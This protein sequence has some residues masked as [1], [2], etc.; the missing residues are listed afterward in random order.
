[1]REREKERERKREKGR[2]RRKER[3]ERKREERKE[4]NERSHLIKHN[5][6]QCREVSYVENLQTPVWISAL[7]S[8]WPKNSFTCGVCSAAE[9]QE[10]NECVF[11]RK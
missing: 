6:T 3:N 2:E 9:D 10:T 8:L 4:K 11:N 7:T 5:F 1:M